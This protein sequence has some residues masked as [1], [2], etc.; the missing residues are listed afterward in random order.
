MPATTGQIGNW[1]RWGADDQLGALNQIT[2]DDVVA[3]AR[4]VR[5]GRIYSLAQP[6]RRSGVPCERSRNPSLHLMRVDG[7]D[8]MAGAKPPGG[9]RATDDYLFM[10]CHGTTHIDA[11]AHVWT[12]DQMYNAIPG[13][14]VRSSGARKLG[15]ENVRG[16]AARG[17]LLDV[18]A[19]KGD[20]HLPAGYAI[21]PAD[22]EGC[23]AAQGVTV[24]RGDVVLVRTGWRGVFDRDPDAYY[25]SQ[26]GIGLACGPW[27]VARDVVAVGADNVAVEVDPPED[28]KGPVPLHVELIRNHGIYLLELLELDELARDRVFEFLF[29]AAP[30]RIIGGVGSPLNP[31]AVC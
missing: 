11:L 30:L 20:A 2:P 7:A 18:A 31:L 9:V 12:G 26:P 15:I 16:I 5:R 14:Q 1:G 27:I 4:L 29:V 25:R 3:A 6:I 17:V 23:A 22:L 13:A 24:G 10:A 21:T 28:G 19:F 8:Y